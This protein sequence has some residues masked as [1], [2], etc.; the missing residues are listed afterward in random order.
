MGLG[1]R[2]GGFRGLGE[3]G[4]ASLWAGLSKGSMVG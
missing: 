3:M 1:V 2:G 4:W